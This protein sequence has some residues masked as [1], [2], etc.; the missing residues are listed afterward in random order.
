[1]ADRL[2][3]CCALSCLLFAQQA[4]AQELTDP[5]RP[6]I[7]ME[8]GDGAAGEEAQA[9]QDQ[10]RGLRLIIIRKDRR[11][12]IIDGRTVELGGKV[13]DAKLVEVN[14]GSVVLQGAR[15]RQVM[16]LFPRVKTGE[17]ANPAAA[18]AALPASDNNKTKPVANREKK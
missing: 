1:M 3:A 11:A 12:A 14:E 17:Q 15:G 5:T 18:P 16:T 8:A 4:S 7:S 6:A 2:I 13:G 9:E 10:T